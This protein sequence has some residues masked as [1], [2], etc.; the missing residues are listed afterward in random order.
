MFRESQNLP[1]WILLFA[2]CQ[3]TCLP[4]LPNVRRLMI[5]LPRNGKAAAPLPKS[6]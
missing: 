1:H 3:G 4:P 5:D 2:T 6:Y